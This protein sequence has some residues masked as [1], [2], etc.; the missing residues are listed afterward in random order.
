MH[1]KVCFLSPSYQLPFPQDMHF[2]LESPTFYIVYILLF[3]FILY[4]ERLYN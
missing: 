4:N 1:S 3:N 2:N